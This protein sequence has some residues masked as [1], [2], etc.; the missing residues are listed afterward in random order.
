MIT[1][2]VAV[3]EEEG[4]ALVTIE[5]GGDSGDDDGDDGEEGGITKSCSFPS[6]SSGFC[7]FLS[8]VEKAG[9]V[10]MKTE[11]GTGTETGMGTGTGAGTA[12][13]NRKGRRT[14][15]GVVGV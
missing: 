10:G 14:G 6:P 13:G 4:S 2:V 9:D 5:E 3:V 8:C 7:S 15:G 12:T 1:G 11:S